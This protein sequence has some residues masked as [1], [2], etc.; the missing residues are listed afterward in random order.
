MLTNFQAL[1]ARMST[2]IHYL[3]SHLGQFPENLGEVS[4]EQ[5]KRFHQAIENMEM[6]YQGRW[7]SRMM[8]D[9]CWSLMRDSTQQNYKRKSYKRA[10]QQMDLPNMDC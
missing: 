10:F 6:K 3:F 1:G 5:G 8:S 9:Y 4:E 2:K 7:D